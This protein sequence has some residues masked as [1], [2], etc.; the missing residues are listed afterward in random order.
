M[1]VERDPAGNL[2]CTGITA[3]H[4]DTLMHIPEWLESDDA[5]VRERLLPSVYQDP[6]D[7]EQWRKYGVPEIEHLFAS[8]ARIVG[9]DLESLGPGGA[10]NIKRKIPRPPTP[11]GL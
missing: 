9:K 6:A 11:P 4:A 7:E 5:R 3:L 2:W 10:V 8:R 1:H